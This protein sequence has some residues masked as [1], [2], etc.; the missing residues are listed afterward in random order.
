[1]AYCFGLL[2]MDY[3]LPWGM[4][5]YCC[6]LLGFPVAWNRYKRI[7]ECNSI[8]KASSLDKARGSFTHGH[9][10]KYPQSLSQVHNQAAGSNPR[11][12]LRSQYTGPGLGS[13]NE[14]KQTRNGSDRSGSGRLPVPSIPL[15]GQIQTLNSGCPYPNPRFWLSPAGLTKVGVSE[16]NNNRNG[17]HHPSAICAD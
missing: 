3:E 14:P 8:V 2:S 1:M 13:Q 11:G 5:A 9:D 6:R 10:I 7:P 15:K 16:T 4:L 12:L 17:Y